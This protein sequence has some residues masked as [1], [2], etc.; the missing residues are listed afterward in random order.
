MNLSNLERKKHLFLVFLRNCDISHNIR[1]TYK[2]L[3]NTYIKRITFTSLDKKEMEAVHLRL[4]EIGL[5]YSILPYDED[6]FC[7]DLGEKKLPITEEILKD[8]LG[9]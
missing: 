5:N 4:K 7:F 3:D 1:T 9:I 8:S 2:L 6:Y